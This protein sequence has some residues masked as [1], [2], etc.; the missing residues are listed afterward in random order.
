MGKLN[1]VN[2]IKMMGLSFGVILTVLSFNVSVHAASPVETVP[3]VELERYMG[4]WYE[5]ASFPQRF[6][7]GCTG[8]T[9]EYSIRQNGKV[10]VLNSCRLN[11]LDGP[12]KSATG[13]AHVVDH[14]TNAKLKVT[15]FWPFY[16]DYWILDLGPN[17]EYA[18]VGD[19]SR[20]YL[21]FLSRTP[22][23][24]PEVLEHLRERADQLGF[25]LAKLRMTLQP[26]E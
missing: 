4:K 12:K 25:D 23:I 17:Y 7:K 24:E 5:I 3:F 21:W 6:Q 26:T 13:T 2:V 10:K 11:S 14:E 22:S 19:S 15:F 18:M 16:G 8:S 20:K 1:K 9:A